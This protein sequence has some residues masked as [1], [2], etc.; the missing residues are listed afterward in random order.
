MIIPNNWNEIEEKGNS[1]G[2]K[3]LPVGAYVC[4]IKDARDYT[5]PTTG[6]LSYKVCVDIAEG[7]YKGYFQKLYDN[8]NLSERKWDNNATK[9]LSQEQDNMGFIKGFITSVNNSNN[10][11][12]RLEPGRELDDSQFRGLKVLGVFRLEEYRN[13]K[14]ELKTKTKLD[15]FRSIDSINNV[16]IP[17]VH[18]IDNTYMDYEEYL[19]LKNTTKSQPTTTTTINTSDLPF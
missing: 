1:N 8:N 18:L 15:S 16:E 7:E 17:S 4:V 9:Y 10:T 11:T 12:I 6:K 13:Q 5:N 19:K 2:F 14:G 3:A